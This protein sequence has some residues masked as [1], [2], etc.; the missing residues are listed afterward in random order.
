[1][2]SLLKIIDPFVSQDLIINLF[3]ADDNLFIFNWS[4]LEKEHDKLMNEAG[5]MDEEGM[6]EFLSD[7]ESKF[8]QITE[9]FMDHDC[10]EKVEQKQWVPFGVLGLEHSPESFAEMNNNGLL[11]FDLTQEDQND[12]PIILFKDSKHQ[13]IAKNFAELNITEN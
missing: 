9:Y 1:M 3:E 10:E 8:T 13:V 7:N 5:D 12:P 11:L 2:K 6:D 4:A